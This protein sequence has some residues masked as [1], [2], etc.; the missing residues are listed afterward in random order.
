[1]W[2]IKQNCDTEEVWYI[3]QLDDYGQ[4][5]M[6][7]EGPSKRSFSL[8]WDFNYG[9]HI[10]LGRAYASSLEEASRELAPR[11]EDI[12]T[13]LQRAAKIMKGAF[14]GREPEG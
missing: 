10:F 5:L 2:R 1:M 4:F 14:D 12:C 8:Y 6:I 3:Q 9:R 7:Q 13:I 11:V